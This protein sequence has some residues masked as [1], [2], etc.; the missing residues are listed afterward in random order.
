[1][2]KYL[3][4]E[5]GTIIGG[6]GYG[7]EGES[8][9]ELVFTTSMSGYIETITDP[10]YAGQILIFAFP[11]IANY[12]V[13]MEKMESEKIQV[14]GLITKDAHEIFSGG[15][16][17]NDFNEFL[18]RSGVPA[19]DGIDT[20]VLV[21][22]IR[23]NGVLRCFIRNKPE[24]PDEFP[25]TM[26]DDLVGLVSRKEYQYYK[27][28]DRRKI[29]FIDVGTKNSLITNLGRI[30]SLHIVP[31]NYDFFN[32]KLDYDAVFIPNGPGNPDHPALKNLVEFIREVSAEK[33][34]IGVCLGNQL[35]TL[36]FGGRTKKMKFGHRGVNHAVTDGTRIYITSHNHGYAVDNESLRNTDLSM[37]MWDINDNTVEMVE[38]RDLPV[39]SVQ[40]HPEAHP[41]PYDGSWF[42][43]KIDETLGVKN[44]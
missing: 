3:I 42:F 12:S 35:I 23:K 5:D 22:K 34:V 7:Y 37:R 13:S 30:A 29:L 40:F 15:P 43:D 24:I 18:K 31:Y 9:G 26:N 44:D 20:R 25:D 16:S 33:P 14:A 8:H 4:L 32:S 11:E 36:A 38:H 6:R 21:E 17:G 27:G 2:D 28:N 41:G 10:S 19:I 39:Y 1:M